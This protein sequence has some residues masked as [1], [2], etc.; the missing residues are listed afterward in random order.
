MHH[1]VLVRPG[2]RKM[3]VGLVTRQGRIYFTV[4]FSS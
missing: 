3:G 4:D 2:W 1:D